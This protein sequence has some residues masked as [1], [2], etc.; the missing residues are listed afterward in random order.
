MR[1]T[2]AG[3]VYF[4]A[5]RRFFF[6]SRIVILYSIMY[7]IIAVNMVFPS[8]PTVRPNEYVISLLSC[9]TSINSHEFI[10]VH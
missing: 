1:V 7:F 5:P 8:F 9:S 4:H 2:D 10:D 6:K 3:L